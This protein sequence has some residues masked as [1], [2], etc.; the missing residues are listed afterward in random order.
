MRVVRRWASTPARRT[1]RGARH[2]RE[3]LQVALVESERRPAR[4]V[5]QH[6]REPAACVGP[7]RRQGLHDAARAERTDDQAAIDGPVLG[8]RLGK[9]QPQAGRRQLHVHRRAPQ[10]LEV[11]V[12]EAGAVRALTHGDLDV[13]LHGI[14]SLLVGGSEDDV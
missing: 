13:Q 3:G 14:A 8:T 2:D 6:E 12:G 4:E 11:D 1:A 10:P 5:R 7:R 9:R